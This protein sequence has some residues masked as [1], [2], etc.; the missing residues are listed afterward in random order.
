LNLY[1]YHVDMPGLKAAYHWNCV[2]CHEV[3]D[4]PTGCQ[5]CH[6]RTVEGDTFYRANA[7]DTSTSGTSG[8]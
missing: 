6:A 1:Q 2:G 4:G 7:S 8:H 5:D 3:M